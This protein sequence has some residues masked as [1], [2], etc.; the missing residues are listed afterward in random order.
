METIATILNVIGLIFLVFGLLNPSKALFWSKNP[1]RVKVLLIF[2]AYSVIIAIAMP[3]STKSN[4]LTA[5]ITKE[6]PEKDNERRSDEIV[7]Y[8][9]AKRQISI[10]YEEQ[11]VN[12][13]KMKIVVFINNESEY[14]ANGKLDIEVVSASDRDRLG[15]DVIYVE[16]LYPTQETYAILWVK[17]SP[18]SILDY[19][20]SNLDFS[21]DKTGGKYLKDS[22][23]KFLKDKRE[24]GNKIE[25]YLAEDKDFQNMFDFIK[26]RNLP[27]GGFYFAVFV[28]DEDFA[29][30]SKFPITAMTFDDET[31][32]HIIATY[33]YNA[34]NGYKEFTYYEKNKLESVAK[35]LK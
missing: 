5:E 6:V 12:D 20:W 19:E 34:K 24:R 27:Q 17:P 22:P 21:K 18:A 26:Q 28:D 35:T 25:F 2:I 32:K 29:N 4:D 16:N 23:Y 1:S 33:G 7:D 9:S 31:S 14:I 11:G 13:G 15:R 8:Q 3:K 10:R 30:F